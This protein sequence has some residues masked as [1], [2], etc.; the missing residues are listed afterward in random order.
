MVLTSSPAT[1]SVVVFP[2]QMIPVSKLKNARQMQ[3]MTPQAPCTWKASRGSSI[4]SLF[5]IR[6]A[7]EYVKD[8]MH[9]VRTAAH[10]C[11]EAHPAVIATRP[12]RIPFV[13]AWKSMMISLF[14]PV[15]CFLVTK[16]RRPAA[17]GDKIVL[18]IALSES[19][20]APPERAAEDP[21]LKNNHPSQRIKVPRTA[22]YGEWAVIYLCSSF[23]TQF[24]TNS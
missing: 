22:C 10:G 18:I 14:S 13:K 8:P 24:L 2:P 17:D 6:Q 15:M 16:V 11:M 3:P 21:A 20:L 4:L 12:A 23:E 5:M 19:A 7:V 9:P 1:I